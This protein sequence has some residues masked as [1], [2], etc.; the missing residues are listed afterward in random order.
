MTLDIVN[1][2][3][4]YKPKALFSSVWWETS[5]KLISN[6]TMADKA[7]ALELRENVGFQRSKES[8]LWQYL[9]LDDQQGKY[10]L[11]KFIFYQSSTWATKGHL[12]RR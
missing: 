5:T 8:K 1:S 3:N 9:M 7:S 2:I 4:D 11:C 6:T 12:Q 10:V